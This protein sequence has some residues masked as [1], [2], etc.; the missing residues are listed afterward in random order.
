MFEREPDGAIHFAGD[1][2]RGDLDDLSL[3]SGGGAGLLPCTQAV[4]GCG[5][6]VAAARRH[7]SAPRVVDC[8][9]GHGGSLPRGAD[10]GLTSH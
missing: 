4:A 9:V 5:D 7:H 6:I 2:E 1:A 3:T 10:A 8:E